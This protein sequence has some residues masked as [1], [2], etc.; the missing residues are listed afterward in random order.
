MSVFAYNLLHKTRDLSGVLSTVIAAAPRFIGLF[1]SVPAA[2]NTKHEWLEDQIS[3]RGLTVVSN[4]TLTATVS[5]ADAAKIKVGTLLGIKDDSALFKVTAKTTTTFTYALAAANGSS[6]TAMAADDAV[7]IIGFPTKEASGEGDGEQT[8][9]SVGSE[10]NNTMIVRKEIVVSGTAMAT[11]THDQVENSINR[12]TEFAFME[13]ARDLNR[14]A[15]FA[16][17]VTPTSSVNGV[18]GGLYE[19][20]TQTGGLSVVGG[21]ARFDTFM[22]NDAAALILDAGGDPD[23]ILCSPGQARVLSADNL[24]KIR[25]IREDLRRGSFVGQIVNDVTGK[26]MQVVAD[27]DFLDTEPWIVDSDGFGLSHL[28]GRKMTDKDATNKDFDG[29]KRLAIGEI[30]LEFKNAKQRLCRI[31]GA[32][33]SAAALAAIKAG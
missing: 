20:G 6:T 14:L 25:I 26:T 19:F 33:G 27:P 11:T 21:G 30:T 24:D 13:V 32:Q 7:I 5:E 22:V 23:T 1:K 17:R 3:G 31:S 29:I 9:R 15:I 18:F 16:N 4:A 10:Y 28:Q 2:K 8:F 12:Q